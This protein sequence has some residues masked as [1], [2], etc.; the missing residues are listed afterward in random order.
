M[1]QPSFAP[2]LDRAPTDVEPPKVMPIGSYSWIIRGM[3]RFDKSTQKKTDFV[4]FTVVPQAPLEDVDAEALDAALTKKNGEKIALESK[5]QRLTFYLT[6]DAIYRLKDFLKHCGF[7]VDDEEQSLRQM[8][9]ETPNRT[10][11]GYISHKPS[12]DGERMYANIT[13][14]FALE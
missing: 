10:F 7:D 2:I 11:G 1:N 4:E 3:P 5:S 6:E 9:N 14:T 8:L 12:E 13:R